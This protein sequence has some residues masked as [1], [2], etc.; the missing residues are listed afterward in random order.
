[1]MEPL[2]ISWKTLREVFSLA[3]I[4]RMAHARPPISSSAAWLQFSRVPGQQCTLISRH[5]WIL[6][7]TFSKRRVITMTYALLAPEFITA[8]ALRQYMAAK[9]IVR[10]Y[11]S[12]IATRKSQDIT[13][14]HM[15]YRRLSSDKLS[16][17]QY[18]SPFVSWKALAQCQ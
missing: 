15:E 16:K 8:W 6:G 4:L 7:G 13:V 2:P 10:V 3:P 9:A 11:N 18:P 14:K 1:M 17:F 12:E 5:R